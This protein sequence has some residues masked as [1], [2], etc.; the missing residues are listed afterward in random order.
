MGHVAYFY[1]QGGVSFGACTCSA[2]LD[3]LFTELPRAVIL[4][5][6][7]VLG[8]KGGA[9]VK[10]PTPYALRE[11]V[12]AYLLLLLPNACRYP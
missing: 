6:L 8:I 3:A 7:E 4:G 1:R 2:N 10:A 12:L 9:E 11:R 5:N